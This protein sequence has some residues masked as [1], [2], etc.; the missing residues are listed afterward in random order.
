MKIT[1]GI[2]SCLLG[3]EVRHDG[4][5]KRNLYVMN[6][7]AEYFSFRPYCPEM[8]IGLGVPRPTIRLTRHDGAIRLTGSSDTGLDLTDDMNSWSSG[9][10]SGM[11]EVSGFILK[12]DS[13]SC[14]MERVRVYD[15]KG[16]PSRDGVGLFA[17]ALMQAM[18]WLPV[19][20]EGRLNDPSLR[21][22]FIERVFTYYRWR[23]MMSSGLTIPTLM[24]F[25]QRHKFI[26]LAHDEEEY[27]RLGRLVAGVTRESLGE[28]A[29]EYLLRMMALLKSRTSRK[30]NTNVLMHVMGY[31][32]NRIEGDDKQ[33]LLEVLD[34]YRLGK[35]PLIV[36]ITLMRHHLRRFPDDYIDKQYFMAPYP[37]EL[38]LR[39]M[40]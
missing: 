4:G 39:N 7:L 15:S 38:M 35:V 19:E 30:R 33:E 21:E 26:L 10:V 36:P 5:H 18:P 2:S 37:E 13:A 25:H 31:L 1:I 3:N 32:K 29:R 20:E 23:Q 12:K 28:T 24:D 27:R 34:S 6:T 22:N 9:A 17:A 11:D 16:A 14:G 8:A 40:I